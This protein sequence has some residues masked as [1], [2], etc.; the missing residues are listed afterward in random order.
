MRR[1]YLWRHRLRDEITQD[2]VS[3]STCLLLMLALLALGADALSPWD[4][5]LVQLAVETNPKAWSTFLENVPVR[6]SS[7]MPPHTMTGRQLG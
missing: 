5:D 7:P 4:F 2:L 3:M 6:P 1:V